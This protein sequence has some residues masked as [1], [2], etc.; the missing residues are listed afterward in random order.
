MTILGQHT[1]A[2]T[3]DLIRSVEYRANKLVSKLRKI[4]S[5]R[6]PPLSDAQKELDADAFN[7]MRRWT[8]TRD[9][10]TLMMTAS[11]IA[12][13][14]VP[15]SVLTA[16]GN[17]NAIDKASRITPP[18]LMDIQNRIEMEGAGLGLAPITLE[19]PSQNSPDADFTALKTLDAAIAKGESAAKSASKGIVSSIP[20]W[21]WGAGAAALGG[22]GYY[23]YRMVKKVL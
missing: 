19:M 17:W 7:F 12:N 13:P 22:Y 2:E 21:A 5:L 10:N 3:R 6:V 14:F 9:A 15:T 23:N 8:D 1:V 16:E 18:R 11:V 4:Q 20:W